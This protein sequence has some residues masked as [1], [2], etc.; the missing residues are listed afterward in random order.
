MAKL[1]VDR[2]KYKKDA[3]VIKPYPSNGGCEQNYHI[4]WG[5]AARERGIRKNIMH[6]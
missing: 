4:N 1:W 6:Q 5:T 3:S 2:I